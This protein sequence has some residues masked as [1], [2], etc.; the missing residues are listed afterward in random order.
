MSESDP[1]TYLSRLVENYLPK[2]FVLDL[3]M[4]IGSIC[5]DGRLTTVI[6]FYFGTI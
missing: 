3:R 4:R 2:G 6:V 5:M 1:C